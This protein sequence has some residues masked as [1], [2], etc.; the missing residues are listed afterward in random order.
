[1]KNFALVVVL[2]LAITPA[3]TAASVVTSKHDL[4]SSNGG[5]ITI[6]TEVCVSCHTPHQPTGQTT[7]PL[8]NHTLSGQ[9]SYGVY[10]STTFN[11]TGTIIDVGGG[12]SAT[13]LCLSCHDGLVAVGSQYNPQNGALLG[14]VAAGN[15]DGSGIITGNPLV[16]V[17]LTNDHPVN[18]LYDAALVTADTLAAGG[19]PG[20]KAPGD[21]GVAPLLRTGR[22]QCSSCHDPHDNQFGAFLVMANTNSVLCTT[23]HIK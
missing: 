22:V 11:G 12:T 13:N 17:D 15:V 14:Y 10:G 19:T 1:M 20:L 5:S 3:L 23:C 16:G 18:F 2:T 8:W 7:D 6:Q 4:R 9:A 21:L